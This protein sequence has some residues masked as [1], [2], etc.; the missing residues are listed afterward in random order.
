MASEPIVTEDNSSS[1]SPAIAI[2]S[3]S[4]LVA[5]SHTFSLKLDDGNYLLWRQHVLFAVRGHSLE[6]FLFDK[7][8]CPEK[9]LSDED[10]AANKIYSE[11]TTCMQQD[12]LLCSWLCSSMFE[13]ILT[14]MVGCNTSKQ[15]WTSL[16][17]YFQAQTAAKI[18]K[19]T[20]QL[21]TIKK[22][23]LTLNA[24][25]LKIKSLTDKLASTGHP[26]T[27][28]EHV[29]AIFRALPTSYDP[30]IIST[31]SRT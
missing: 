6:H 3:T 5:F 30:F 23:G 12:Q 1:S 24:Y 9:F 26:L 19:L 25:L 2:A 22:N 18:D 8:S 16:Q 31:N 11:Y 13:S 7:D 14:H 17:I 4:Q 20:T 27:A 28:K 21:Q 29:Q 10:K 15:V